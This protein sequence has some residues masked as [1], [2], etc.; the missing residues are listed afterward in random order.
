MIIKHDENTEIANKILV[1]IEFFKNCTIISIIFPNQN[2]FLNKE[3]PFFFH[4]PEKNIYQMNEILWIH[5]KLLFSKNPQLIIGMYLNCS[6]DWNEFAK[7][8]LIN[9]IKPNNIK[10]KVSCGWLIL[11]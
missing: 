7:I 1:I 9:Y 6:F 5:K 11:Y 10:N 4:T 3:N 2:F 8:E